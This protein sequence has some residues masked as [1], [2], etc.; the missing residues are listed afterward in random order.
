LAAGTYNLNPGIDFAGSSNVMLQGAGA[1]QTLL[2]ITGGGAACHNH[3][4]NVCLALTNNET[5]WS[6]GPTN[7]SNWTAGYAQGT[8]NI[9]L[10][11]V[12]NLK[13]G[14]M[15]ILDQAD[16][17]ADTGS[18][19]V[20]DNNTISPPCSLESNVGNSQRTHRNQR[21]FVTV[22][23]CGTVTTFGAS[24]NGTNVTI[25]PG[26][27]MNNWRASQS[28]GAWWPTS[29]LFNSGV[30]NLSIDGTNSVGA[31]GIVHDNCI[32]C[33]TRGVRVIAF[34]KAGNEIA[35]SVRSSVLDSYFY[36]NQTNQTS[37]YAS[38]SFGTSD[39][40]IQNNIFQYSAGPL[41]FNSDCTGCVA[42]YNFLIN[43]FYTG[44]SGWSMPGSSQHTAGTDMLLYEGNVGAQSA[45]D[46]F[47][48][49]HNFITEF[50]NYWTGT[51]VKCWISGSYPTATFGTCNN[52][53]LAV[54][55]RAYSRFYNFVGNVLGTQGINT[56]YMNNS[57]ED[58]TIYSIGNGNTESGVT[59]PNDP[60]VAATLFRWGNYDVVN[61]SNRFLASEVPTG[62]GTYAN[63]VPASQVLPSSFYL[64]TRPS[65][66]RSMPWPA[67]GPDVTGGSG[68]GL[69][70]HVYSNPAQ[71][72]Y[73]NVMHGPAD[74][75]GSVLTFNADTCYAGAT[76]PAPPAPP[77]NLIITVQ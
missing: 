68:T 77:T 29:P 7:T 25:T 27:R 69:G 46:N 62:I 3:F 8:T 56:T 72:C 67:I 28:P 37:A 40:L 57:S 21:Q 23:S 66:W 9:T 11:S 50:R 19:F 45:A 33:V 2:V 16:D 20:C 64:S 52:D 58:A 61:A 26:L 14:Y 5:N 51:Q 65:W 48:G 12:T 74:G 15:L 70:G 34:G 10:S 75:T 63:P 6:G 73:L 4:G 18:V 22:A 17:P 32:G 49:T 55:L 47:H 59:V 30:S 13:V 39:S 43:E 42:G 76:A 54:M 71:D 38:E 31:E 36:L 60:Q 35:Y 44:S 1:N 41:M 24:C 53:R